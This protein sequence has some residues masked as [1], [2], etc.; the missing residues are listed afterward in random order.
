[1]EF[2]LYTRNSNVDGP[3]LFF[4]AETELKVQYSA[5]KNIAIHSRWKNEAGV[6][7]WTRALGQS[8]KR[9]AKCKLQLIKIQISSS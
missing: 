2:V 8:M 3:E 4:R 6:I 1:M 9:Y 5:L 7:F